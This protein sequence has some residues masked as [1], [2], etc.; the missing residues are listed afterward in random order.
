MFSPC[1]DTDETLAAVDVLVGVLSAR[2]HH[3]LRQAIRDT[4]LGYLRDH[5]LFQHRSVRVCP[6][7]N[8]ISPPSPPVVFSHLGGQNWFQSGNQEKKEE[9]LQWAELTLLSLPDQWPTLSPSPPL[10]PPNPPS[11]SLSLARPYLFFFRLL[12]IQ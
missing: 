1:C 12:L 5:P 3:E 6:G 11:L 10:H 2:H 7:T 9:S 8:F 4:W